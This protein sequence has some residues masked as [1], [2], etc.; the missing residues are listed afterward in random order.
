MLP[1]TSTLSYIN[2][3]NSTGLSLLASMQL[4]MKSAQKSLDVPERKQNLT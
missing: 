1:E 4:V 2:A 3:T